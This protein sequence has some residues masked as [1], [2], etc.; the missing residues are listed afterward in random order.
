MDDQ[1]DLN[2]KCGI[3][4]D[5]QGG[6]RLKNPGK[7]RWVLMCVGCCQLKIG[8]MESG[9]FSLVLLCFLPVFLDE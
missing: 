2:W 9:L 6:Q 5:D 1:G 4:I 3:L 8:K 7:C